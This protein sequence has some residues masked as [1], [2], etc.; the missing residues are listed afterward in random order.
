MPTAGRPPAWAW[1]GD[2]TFHFDGGRAPLVLRKT[3]FN[4]NCL[5]LVRNGIYFITIGFVSA[6]LLIRLIQLL[7]VYFSVLYHT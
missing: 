3:A 4:L 5:L 1:V 2:A 6:F 7:P